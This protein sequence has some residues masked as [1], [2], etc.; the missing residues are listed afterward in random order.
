VALGATIAREADGY[1]VMHVPE[2]NN[3]CLIDAD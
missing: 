3:F 2:G 1:T